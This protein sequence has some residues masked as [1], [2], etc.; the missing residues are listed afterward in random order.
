MGNDVD[1][2]RAFNRL[3]EIIDSEGPAFYSGPRFISK[4]REVGAFLPSYD[5]Y[6]AQRRQ[7]RKSTMR[8]DYFYDILLELDE[9]LRVRLF[10]LILDDVETHSPERV[11]ELRAL[12]G[13]A[14]PRPV[15]LAP[16]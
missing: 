14:I 9:P 13:G 8:R 7:R 2:V 12:L 4:V 10:H 3:F 6:I 16:R 11:R 5:L 1:W 15:N